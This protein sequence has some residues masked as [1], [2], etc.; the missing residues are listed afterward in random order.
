MSVGEMKTQNTTF[1]PQSLYRGA[2]RQTGP[3]VLMI[4]LFII[5]A[6]TTMIRAQ[7]PM[8]APARDL[9]GHSESRQRLADLMKDHGN[10]VAH[11]VR[12]ELPMHELRDADGQLTTSGESLFMLLARRIK[13]LSL[14]VT[15]T[16]NSLQDAEFA[17]VIAA[18]M[19]TE[20]NLES[21]RLRIGVHEVSTDPNSANDSL[22]VV[23]IT[24]HETTAG[25]VE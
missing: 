15:L 18:R 9:H 6:S 21:T 2:W 8:N 25:V 16:A 23:T 1:S 14:D 20:S 19:M 13:S 12:V 22:L 4:L 11:S 5:I 7:S 17:A 3:G 10:S 24:M